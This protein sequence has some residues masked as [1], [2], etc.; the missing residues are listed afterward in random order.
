[1]A[2]IS[3]H[4]ILSVLSVRIRPRDEDLASLVLALHPLQMLVKGYRPFAYLMVWPIWNVSLLATVVVMLSTLLVIGISRNTSWSGQVTAVQ[5]HQC[6][7]PGI[8][9]S[10]TAEKEWSVRRESYAG[11]GE[12]ERGLATAMSCEAM[13]LSMVVLV[14][15]ITSLRQW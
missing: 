1:V 9:A 7:L 12:G 14:G 13:S 11:F 15:L 5:I 10:G 3:P 2:A 4:E 6:A 8:R